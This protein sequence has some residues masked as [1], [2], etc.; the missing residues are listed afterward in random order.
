M[1]AES[2]ERGSDRLNK[3]VPREYD[4]QSQKHTDSPDNS[5]CDC[6]IAT[7][8]SA[9]RESHQAEANRKIAA[10]REAERKKKGAGQRGN[11]ES[12]SGCAKRI[13][14]SIM[15][16]SLGSGIEKFAAMP[17][18]DRPSSH[19]AFAIRTRENPRSPRSNWDSRRLA[20]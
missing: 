2:P 14:A 5:S 1:Q 8:K 15:I 7:A 3:N 19:V 6:E 13:T 20:L 16:C 4:R 10:I 9:E 18:L 11:A 17:A 12:Q